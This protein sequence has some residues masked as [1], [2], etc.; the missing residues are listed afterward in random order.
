[1]INKRVG[2]VFALLLVGILA[3]S[4]VSG[5]YYFPNVRSVTKGVIDTY[6]NI[7]EPIL[8]ALFGG[9]GGWTGY[10][11]FERFLLFIL[12]ISI[13][14]IS[15]GKVPFFENQKMTRWIVAIVVPLIGIRFI[16]YDS[17]KSILDQYQILA[18]VL[19][20]ILPFVLFF[21]FV[22]N[23]AGD[24]PFL[25]KVAWM[26]FI[27][28]YAGMWTTASGELASSVYF[29]TFVAAIA[30][31]VFDGFIE[32]QFRRR[33]FAKQGSQAIH[34]EIGQTNKKIADVRTQIVN[35]QIDEKAGLDIIKRWE[36]HIKELM[37]EL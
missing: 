12:L 23:L 9:Y 17:L 4:L 36:K 28:I 7:G 13:V 34:L 10:L 8:Q 26:V 31:L 6:V 18:I 19:T 14:Y 5:Y 35:R 20:S 25:R 3:S 22:H 21:Y 30:S 15:I 27:G 11:L 2:F 32:R 1:M 24:Y 16:N 29:W 37:D 33:Q